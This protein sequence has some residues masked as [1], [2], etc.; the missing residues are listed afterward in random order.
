MS[1]SKVST[2]DGFAVG[3]FLG[4]FL[5]EEGYTTINADR[6]AYIVPAYLFAQF[7]RSGY[8]WYFIGWKADE[9]ERPSEAKPLDLNNIRLDFPGIDLHE[10][11]NEI[12]AYTRVSWNTKCIAMAQPVKSLKLPTGEGLSCSGCGDIAFHT[13]ANMP[14]GSFKCYSCRKNP[15]R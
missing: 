11:T 15:Y 6:A 10:I 5:D 8:P 7:D 9:L 2:I 3:D 4:I 13:E 12:T 1:R 14:D